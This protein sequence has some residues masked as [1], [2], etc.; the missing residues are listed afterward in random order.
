MIEYKCDYC[1]AVFADPAEVIE[2]N[3]EKWAGCPSCGGTSLI[4]GASCGCCGEFTEDWY[5]RLCEN[6]RAD[7]DNQILAFLLDLPIAMRKSVWLHGIPQFSSRE[8]NI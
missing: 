7:L 1:G 8:L 6:C 5:S 4:E 3:G 2:D